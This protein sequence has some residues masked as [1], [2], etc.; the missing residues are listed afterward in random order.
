MEP[1]EV[2]AKRFLID[3]VHHAASGF[4]RRDRLAEGRF[5]AF[6]VDVDH[7]G[8]LRSP[9]HLQLEFGQD[10]FVAHSLFG[11]ATRRYPHRGIIPFNRT[12][13]LPKWDAWQPAL[14][15]VTH[16]AA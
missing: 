15:A 6:T 5:L 1:F 12:E 11:Y 8:D 7:A 13:L 2:G 3:R 14:L 9:A 16:R 4:L 10:D